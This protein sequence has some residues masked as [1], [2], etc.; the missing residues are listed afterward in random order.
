MRNTSVSSLKCYLTKNTLGP[1]SVRPC[2]CTDSQVRWFDPGRKDTVLASDPDLTPSRPDHSPS[3]TELWWRR[4]KCFFG[5]PSTQNCRQPL[6]SLILF[7]PRV[8]YGPNPSDWKMCAF[9]QKQNHCDKTVWKSLFWILRTWMLMRLCDLL[10]GLRIQHCGHSVATPL[11]NKKSSLDICPTT[12]CMMWAYCARLYANI[13]FVCST[14]FVL[15]LT[16][17]LTQPLNPGWWRHR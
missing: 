5:G 13:Y 10:K 17:T 16:L 1:I 6:K 11:K 15:S 9:T 2:G 4:F 3:V 14:E 12:E 8:F 7:F